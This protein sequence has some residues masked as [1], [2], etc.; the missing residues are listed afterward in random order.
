MTMQ[1]C[2]ALGSFCSVR[3]T[4]LPEKSPRA[5]PRPWSH[6][7]NRRA[8]CTGGAEPPW[9]LVEHDHGVRAADMTYS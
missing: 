4:R 6:H 7:Q 8:C 2:I 9:G 5:N 3:R 1:T